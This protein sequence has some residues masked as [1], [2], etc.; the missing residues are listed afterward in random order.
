[1]G[2][3]GG[4][5][6]PYWLK[7]AKCRLSLRRSGG[8]NLEAT[9]KTLP[10]SKGQRGRGGRRVLQ[11]RV[12]YRCLDCKHVGWSRHVDAGVLLEKLQASLP[13]SA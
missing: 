3:K 4:T 12:Q 9:G 10:L 11:L 1:M 13:G 8:M 2:T 6:Q 5:G 7:C